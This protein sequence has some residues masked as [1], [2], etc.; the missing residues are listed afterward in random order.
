MSR[1]SAG[2]PIQDPVARWLQERTGGLPGQGLAVWERPAKYYDRLDVPGGG[3]GAGSTPVTELV[4]FRSTMQRGV[5]NLPTPNQL[6]ANYALAL[7]SI[8]LG[9]LPGFDRFARRL[10]QASPSAAQILGSSMAVGDTI[11]AATQ[12][13]ACI[14]PV[15]WHETIRDFF[16]NAIV[17][18]NVADRPVFEMH[19]LGNF[20]DG[21][22]IAQGTTTTSAG[23][24]VATQ[25]TVQTFG[26]INNGV[27]MLGN[28]MSFGTPY[29]LPGGQNF[30]VSVTW[31]RAVDWTE[32]NMGPLVAFNTVANLIA[33]CLTCELEGDLASPASS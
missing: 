33:G 20:P 25:Y 11:A 15:K 14:L 30:N 19:G 21:K 31:Q 24:G 28:M 22:G 9:F 17:T 7:R 10:G 2:Y 27:P 12:A 16:A 32:T 4:F 29:P 13:A 23:T 18:F 3:T 6:P 8:R 5:S 26:N 1:I